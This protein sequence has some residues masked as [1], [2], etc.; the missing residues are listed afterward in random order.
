MT[1]T[2]PSAPISADAAAMDM[3]P[4]D[5]GPPGGGTLNVEDTLDNGG[6][7]G[8]RL[9]LVGMIFFAFFIDG[10]AQM[11]LGLTIP[12][13]M[14]DWSL[15]ASAFSGAMAAN[16]I[17]GGLGALAGGMLS[18]KI[19]RKPILIA[20]VFLFGGATAL[21][22][23]A[24]NVVVLSLLLF[25]AG[26]GVGGLNPPGLI[27][28]SEYSPRKHR[29]RAVA[30]AVA[31]VMI[32]ATASGFIAAWVLSHYSWHALFGV[33]GVFSIAVAVILLLLLPESPRYMAMAKVPDRDIT[34][35]LR[36][37]GHAVEEKVSLI[38]PEQVQSSSS[39]AP[40]FTNGA[41]KATLVLWAA[42]FSNVLCAGLG[43]GW[44][45][46]M[47]ANEGYSSA[48]S[49]IA[50][51]AWSI[52]GVAGSL[53][54]GWLLH[55]LPASRAAPYFGLIGVVV[56]IVCVA[57]LFQASQGIV[58]VTLGLLA[59]LGFLISAQASCLFALA[60]RIY[61]PSASSTGVGTASTVSRLGAVCSS[62]V[63]AIAIS[64]GGA[65]GFFGILT[66]MIV[67]T[68]AGTF[69]LRQLTAKSGMAS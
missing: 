11:V 15:P 18:D 57:G 33:V 23:F 66:I 51:S 9:F 32:G 55:R 6:W 5:G 19:G 48:I 4:A 62:F 63:G 69:G 31:S 10:I 58:I 38:R 53:F 24:N 67:I 26:L 37:L 42:F 50:P 25:A 60:A 12:S 29:E 68:L 27:L 34:Q 40:L 44:L 49:S 54:V 36:K 8:Y 3:V 13:L 22:L 21:V 1:T 65:Q 61:P 52:G 59:I 64:A 16:W 43:L 39:L 14:A 2:P 17:G 35:L 45:P 7:N 30:F 47:M 28:A 46:T 56:G 41:W 20:S